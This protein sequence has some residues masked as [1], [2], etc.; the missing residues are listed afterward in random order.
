M[1]PCVCCGC[2][3]SVVLSHRCLFDGGSQVHATVPRP[4]GILIINSS[5]YL[6]SSNVLGR[7]QVLN[8]A[9]SDLAE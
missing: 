9:G 6:G 8:E 4:R 1:A 3:L 5:R 7:L 2:E